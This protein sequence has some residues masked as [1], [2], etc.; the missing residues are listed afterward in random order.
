MSSKIL[1][2][3]FLIDQGRL[4][5][6]KYLSIVI[7]VFILI[8]LYSLN[9]ASRVTAASDINVFW[10]AGRNFASGADLYSRIG[11]ANRYIYP[12][13]AALIYQLLA[14]F[15]LKVT[16]V[17]FTVFNFILF[18]ASIGLTR[19]ILRLF[20]QDKKWIN[21]ALIFGV[22]FSFRFFWYL[23][24]YLQMNEIILVLTLAGILASLKGKEWIAVWCIVIGVFIK[25]IP[26]FFIPW[27]ILRGNFK[28]IFKIAACSAFCLLL[29]LLWRSWHIGLQD[30]QNYYVSF[31]GPFKEGR[32][33]ALFKNQSLSA[34]IYRLCLPNMDG[35]QFKYQLFD[36][37]LAQA[38]MV[39][40]LCFVFF[41]ALF[42]GYLIWERFILKKTTLNGIV[43]V[44]ITMHLLSGITW[45]Y[46]LVSLIF[47]Y[48]VFSLYYRM[49]MKLFA[50]IC[51]YSICVLICIC[52][53]IGSDTMGYMLYH[54]SDGY[55]LVTW[56]MAGLFFFFLFYRS[57]KAFQLKI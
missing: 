30:L 26:I 28:T 8:V 20:I 38:A 11:G 41:G 27:L 32:V 43:L 10:N 18:F 57:D 40:K 56:L 23:V 21:Y 19:E 39:Y 12:P 31:L 33:E 48:A 5:Q 53:L 17:L 49:K 4:R 14:L 35:D 46:H 24:E 42:G 9:M 22:I 55:S 29:P 1:L 36:L 15:Q 47:I 52:S 44:F 16:A 3:I 51:F 34:A 13:F 54:Y 7:S 6:P 50:R 25:V 45:E 2:R 37:T